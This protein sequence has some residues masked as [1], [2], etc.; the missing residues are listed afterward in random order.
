M[1]HKIILL[2]AS[3]GLVAI[4]P[5]HANAE[6]WKD[7]LN[8]VKEKSK[9]KSLNSLTQKLPANAQAANAIQDIKSG[10]L[11]ELLVNKV[12]VTQAQAEGG[13][14]ALFQAA[15]TKMKPESF[16]ELEQSVPGIQS[17]LA[18]V[19]VQPANLGALAGGLS[20]LKGITGN[21][22]GELLAAAYAFKQQGMSPSMIQQF[23]PVVVEY[24]KNNSN[25]ILA[26]TLSSAL[27]GH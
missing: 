20:S 14:G 3:L 4:L 13:A 25:G 18:K 7:A 2:T 9:G 22:S 19:P 1:K 16:A 15:K 26:N 11:T 27:I 12:G 8:S 23:I 21:S 5:N 17:M 10:S 6:N 24:V